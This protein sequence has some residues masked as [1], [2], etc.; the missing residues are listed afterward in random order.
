M[1]FQGVICSDSLL[2]AGVRDRFATEG[3]LAMA[4]LNAG[5]DV[6][7]DFEDPLAV[8]D[9]LTK[10]FESGEIDEQRIDNSLERVIRLKKR[11]FERLPHQWPEI[12]ASTQESFAA[13]AHDAARAAI[14]MLDD[15]RRALPLDV[16]KPTVVVLLKP[17]ETAIEPPEQPLGAALRDVFRDVKYI[18][19][20][21]RADEFTYRSASELARAAKQLVVAMTVRPAAWHAYGLRPEQVKFVQAILR[22]RE[23]VVVAS[24][25]APYALD[26]YPEAVERI[27]TYSDVPVSQLALAQFLAGKTY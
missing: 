18:Q 1:G 12:A 4:A 6:L 7:L 24:L 5:V 20:G 13:G 25:G 27:C 15:N 16:A 2:M 11:V 10:S 26:D 8:I 17:F 3:E 9:H 21:P 19:I 23:D 22:E 14:T